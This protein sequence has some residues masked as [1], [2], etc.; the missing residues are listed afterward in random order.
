MR[1]E[2]ATFQFYCSLL[3]HFISVPFHIENSHLICTKNQM[4][5]HEMQ[6]WTEMD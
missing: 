5:V 3:I 4:T 1:F 2:L 6:P